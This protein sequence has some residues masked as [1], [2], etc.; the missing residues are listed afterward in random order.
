MSAISFLRRTQRRW[1]AASPS[2]RSVSRAP[3]ASRAA[4]RT[5]ACISPG[6]AGSGTMSAAHE[7][8][9]AGGDAGSCSGWKSGSTP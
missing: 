5:A 8:P 1:R 7:V 2:R 3:P 6:S 4:R 9:P